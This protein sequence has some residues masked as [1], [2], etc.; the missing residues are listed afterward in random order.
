M[1]LSAAGL[2]IALLCA[3]W[4][5]APTKWAPLWDGKT[6]NGWHVIG[7]GT[8]TVEDGALVGR[9][10]AADR[11][12][13][14]LVTN[15]TYKDFLVRVT[16]KSLK[17]NSGLYF[18]IEEKGASGVSGFQAEIDPRVDIGGLYETNG[19]GWVV[20]PTAAEIKKFFKPDDWNTMLVSAQGTKVRVEVNGVKTAEIDD[21]KGRRE[22][23]IALQLHGGQEVLVM[24][25][26]L[27]I[28][29]KPVAAKK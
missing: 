8:W 19:R 6:L 4:L 13:G 2:V 23:K 7:K 29:G 28:M 5:P 21:A 3:G 18:R 16:F 20:K 9:H 12:Y 14:H 24:F 27:Q 25:K 22:G 1:R 10:K 11:D 26:D 15:A 17:G